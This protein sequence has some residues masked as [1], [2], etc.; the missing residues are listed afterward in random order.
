[1][2]PRNAGFKLGARVDLDLSPREYCGEALGNKEYRYFAA[3]TF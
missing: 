2:V 1:M 3:I